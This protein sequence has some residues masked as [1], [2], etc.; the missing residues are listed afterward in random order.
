MT[1]YEWMYSKL[2][3]TTTITGSTA[4]YP[5]YMPQD[6][7]VPCIVYSDLSF[8]RNKTIRTQVMS[9]KLIDNTRTA[10]EALSDQVYGLFDNARQ[11][12]RESSSKLNVLNVDIINNISGGYDDVNQNWWKSID[13]K[14]TYYFST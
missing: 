8:D 7:S 2:A 4:I 11:T 9:L 14:I 3:S 6:Y 12:T 13:L 1:I 10:L 5:E